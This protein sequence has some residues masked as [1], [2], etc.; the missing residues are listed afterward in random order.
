MTRTAGPMNNRAV[1]SIPAMPARRSPSG[2]A[3]WVELGH[4]T[5]LQAANKRLNA[6]EPVTLPY[7]LPFH[8]SDVHSGAADCSPAQ[9]CKDG[10]DR[11]EA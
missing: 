11:T 5:R 3:S 7:D 1:S 9:R 4:G 2:S 6:I 8:Q 10:S